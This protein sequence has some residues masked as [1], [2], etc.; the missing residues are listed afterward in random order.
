MAEGGPGGLVAERLEYDDR[1]AP[2]GEGSFGAVFRGTYRRTAGGEEVVAVKQFLLRVDPKAAKEEMA[3]AMGLGHPNIVQVFGCAEVRGL[4]CIVMELLGETL[5]AATAVLPAA[6]G[7]DWAMRVRWLAESAA[8]MAYLHGRVPAPIVH[9]DLKA[10]NVLMTTGTRRVARICDFGVAR[11]LEA[12]NA[13]TYQKGTLRWSAPETLENRFGLASDVWSFAMLMYEVITGDLPFAGLNDQAMLNA[14]GRSQAFKFDPVR[15]PAWCRGG[16]VLL[17]ACRR[18][19][20]IRTTSRCPRQ[21][22]GRSSS[23]DRAGR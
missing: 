2:L 11:A 7:P 9:R 10:A 5:R 17:C 1:V 8:G 18:T 6:G 15:T 13:D 22:S 20:S 3:V 12:T 19:T 21:S 16:E 4:L 14:L 23:A